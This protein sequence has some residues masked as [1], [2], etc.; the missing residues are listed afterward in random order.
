MSKKI[1]ELTQRVINLQNQQ[2]IFV[3][4][5]CPDGITFEMLTEEIIPETEY[6]KS[7]ESRGSLWKTY[8]IAVLSPDP[9]GLYID[10]QQATE[11]KKMKSDTKIPWYTMQSEENSTFGL[12]IDKQQAAEMKKMKSDTNIPRHTMESEENSN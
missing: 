6:K 4:D 5:S 1:N 11:M 3:P 12:Y 8:F 10:K 7:E 2:Y 9:F